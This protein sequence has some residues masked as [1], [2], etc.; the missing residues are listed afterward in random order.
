MLASFLT[1]SAYAIG[2]FTHTYFILPFHFGIFRQVVFGHII[3]GLLPVSWIG[4]SHT[5]AFETGSAET[6]TV[7][8]RCFFDRLKKADHLRTTGF[9]ETDRTITGFKH[10]GAQ[11][12]DIAFFKEIGRAS[13]RERP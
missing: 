9:P 8:A 2:C 6:A 12:R 3:D 4:Q 11:H 10:N 7:Y 1:Y 5:A 13:C